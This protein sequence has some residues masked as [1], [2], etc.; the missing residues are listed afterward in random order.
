MTVSVHPGRSVKMRHVFLGGARD[1][2]QFNGR[3]ETFAHEGRN[4]EDL[5]AMYGPSAYQVVK[6]VWRDAEG[7]IFDLLSNEVMNDVM[8]GITK[9]LALK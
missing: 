6:G 5:T 9:A 3:L 4:A 7:S 2:K 1:G 8:G